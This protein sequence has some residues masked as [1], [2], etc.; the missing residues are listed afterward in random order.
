MSDIQNGDLLLRVVQSWVRIHDNSIKRINFLP[1]RLLPETSA[2]GQACTII[3]Q[4]PGYCAHA[5]SSALRYIDDYRSC[6]LSMIVAGGFCCVVLFFFF[7]QLD[8]DNEALRGRLRAPQ[9]KIMYTLLP[10]PDGMDISSIFELDPTT[11]R[12]GDSMV[13]RY[14]SNTLEETSVTS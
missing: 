10:V 3:T 11:L 1:I 2:S 6:I 9:E 8:A 14:K 4:V 13:P 5:C 12:G 7:N